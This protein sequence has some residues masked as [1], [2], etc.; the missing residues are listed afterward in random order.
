ME[1]KVPNLVD[2]ET[3][4]SVLREQAHRTG[5]SYSFGV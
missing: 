5:H 3:L 1:F 2:V 4:D